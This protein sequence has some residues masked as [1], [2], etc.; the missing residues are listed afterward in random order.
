MSYIGQSIDGIYSH[1]NIEHLPQLP[2][3][4]PYIPTWQELWAAE[5]DGVGTSAAREEDDE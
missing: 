2:Q 5:Q 4:M 3:Q 1:F